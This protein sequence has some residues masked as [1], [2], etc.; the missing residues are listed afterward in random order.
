MRVER[1]QGN[2]NDGQRIDGR[3]TVY[4]GPAENQTQHAERYSEKDQNCSGMR[5]P[6][7]KGLLQML[8]EWPA[9][10]RVASSRSVV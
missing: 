10:A 3:N 7:A 2:G 6:S 9:I 8:L 5:M 1:N 4:H